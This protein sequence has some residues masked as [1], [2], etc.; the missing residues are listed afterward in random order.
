MWEFPIGCKLILASK[1]HKIDL[2]VNIVL[3]F[4]LMNVPVDN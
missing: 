1:L 2:Y 3:G 4:S